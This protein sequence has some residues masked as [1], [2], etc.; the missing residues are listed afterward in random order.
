[1]IKSESFQQSYCIFIST[2]TANSF[3]KKVRE[4]K[5]SAVQVLKGTFEDA[6]AVIVI[7]SDRPYMRIEK[8]LFEWCNKIGRASCRERV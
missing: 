7:P 1:M 5:D 3:A 2:T 6:P 4:Y 8:E